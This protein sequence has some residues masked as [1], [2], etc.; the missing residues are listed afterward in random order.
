M[1]I[2]FAQADFGG[3][4]FYRILQPAAFLKFILH[5]EVKVGFRF[6]LQELLNYDLIVF[7]RQFLPEVLESTKILHEYKKKVIYELDDDMW[8]IPPENE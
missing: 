2:F 4:G 6:N 3:C 7:Q 1:K 5:H 8:G